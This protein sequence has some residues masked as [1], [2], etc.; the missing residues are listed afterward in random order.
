MPEQ[1]KILVVD[2]S[3][4]NRTLLKLLLEDDYQIDEADCGETCL[5]MVKM[6]IPDL[7]LL[8]VQM[9][10][11][12]GYEVCEFLRKQK[13]TE[14][15][16]IIFVSGL[17]SAEERLAGFECGGDEYVIKPVDGLDLIT[18][19]K[20]HLSRQ[21]ERHVQHTDD[22]DAMNIAMEAMT[23]SSELGQIVEFV[24]NGQ[25][26]NTSVDVGE[27][28]LR[29]SQEFQLK[30]S[31]LVNTNMHHYFGCQIESMEAKFLEKLLDAKER[32]L[33]IGIRTIIKNDH[34]VLLIKDMPHDDENR[35]GRLKDHLS[36]L[37]DIADGYLVNIISRTKMTSQRKEFIKEIIA[38]ADKQIEKTSSK[39]QN[40][41]HHSSEI[42]SG[43]LTNLE[44]ML[45]SLGLDDDQEKALMSLADHAS[46]QLETLNKSTKDLDS[47]LGLI[48]KSLN[49]FYHSHTDD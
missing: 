9:P 33:S 29:I 8:D 13:E 25:D 49:E 20:V 28:I 39:L 4:E 6:Q 12:S 2:D 42:M 41:G 14:D 24:K 26:L 27:A 40:Y 5:A 46:E 3:K 43:M 19:V 11:L 47:E 48:V 23:V 10:G 1:A 44:D 35:S 30:T 18:K 22:H 37:M 34:I 21:N 7:I 17:D 36:V 31:V 45:F 16:P 38:I 32:I 15:L